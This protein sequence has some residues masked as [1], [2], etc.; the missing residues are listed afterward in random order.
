MRKLFILASFCFCHLLLFS[1]NA[2]TIGYFTYRLTSSQ[3]YEAEVIDCSYSGSGTITIPDTIELQSK[4]YIVTGIGRNVFLDNTYINNIVLPKNIK[5][6]GLGAFAGTSIRNFVVP[7]TVTFVE[8]NLFG[9]CTNYLSYI[10]NIVVDSLNPIYDSRNNCNGIIET[11]TNKLVCGHRGTIIPNDIKSIGKY[12]FASSNYLWEVFL[13]SSIKSI[14]SC[15]YYDNRYLYHVDFGDSIVKIGYQAFYGCR[16][17]EIDLPNTIQQIDSLAFVNTTYTAYKL[18]E[19]Q[20]IICRAN[21]PP[22][23]NCSTFVSNTIPLYVPAES[24]SLYQTAEVWRNFSNIHSIDELPAKTTKSSYANRMDSV[25]S[26]GLN[27]KVVFT[28][29]N[30]QYDRVLNKWRIPNQQYEVVGMDSTYDKGINYTNMSGQFALST[31]LNNYGT[32]NVTEETCQGQ[33]IDWGNIF[34]ADWRVLT[35]GEFKYLLYERENANNLYGFAKVAGVNGCVILPDNWNCPSDLTFNP[36]VTGEYSYIRY[37]DHNKYSKEDWIKMENAGAVF[38]P[39][40]GG[41]KNASANYPGYSAQ[42]WAPSSHFVTGYSTLLFAQDLISLKSGTSQTSD[43]AWHYYPVRIVHDYRKYQ[44]S[45]STDGNGQADCNTLSA[46]AGDSIKISITPNDGYTVDYAEINQVKIDDFKGLFEMPAE[47]V[48]LIIYF[49]ESSPTDLLSTIETKKNQKIIMDNRI[50][51][52]IDGK[53]FD[54]L[55]IE[56]E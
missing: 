1:Q 53:K 30:L 14:D 11:S 54:I 29:G 9:P 21:V 26:V 22:L 25:F 49:K 24:I 20:R 32:T 38:L 12:A 52:I 44:I 7:S 5:A 56:Y 3:P 10:E 34:G 19:L 31:E 13:P 41:G 37:E 8:A 39:A 2:V 33:F 17:Q 43:R 23:I 40:A 15:A 45:L 50:Y 4:K 36:G 55:G 35:Y 16:L 51:I 48:N 46:L 42:Y 28:K 27:R 47:N 18:Y 6:L